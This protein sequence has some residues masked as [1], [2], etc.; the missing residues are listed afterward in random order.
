MPG[1][2]IAPVTTPMRNKSPMRVRAASLGAQGSTPT[3]SQ[4]LEALAC[5]QVVHLGEGL[6]TRLSRARHVQGAASCRC[7]QRRHARSEAAHKRHA[8]RASRRAPL[9]LAFV[10][11]KRKQGHCDRGCA[12]CCTCRHHC[13]Q[14]GNDAGHDAAEAILLHATLHEAMLLHATLHDHL[15]HCRHHC[16][17][18]TLHDKLPKSPDRTRGGGLGCRVRGGGGGWGVQGPGVCV[19]RGCHEGSQVREGAS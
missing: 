3:A 10:H 7:H 2:W 19:E 18:A 6:H 12:R 13:L 8:A 16:L 5:H 17:Q 4:I 11:R 15:H 9:A 1:I 14:W